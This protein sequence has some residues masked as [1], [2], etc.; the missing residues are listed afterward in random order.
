[1]PVAIRKRSW[2]EHV[3]HP[4]GL[5]YSYDDLD[6]V[7]C[8][9]VDSEGPWVGAGTSKQGQRTRC[10]SMPEGCHQLPTDDLAQALEVTA[11][12]RNG[13]TESEHL[14]LMKNNEKVPMDLQEESVHS[15]HNMVDVDISQRASESEHLQTTNMGN[16][17]KFHCNSNSVMSSTNISCVTDS[18]AQSDKTINREGEVVTE[19]R[20]SHDICN[21]GNVFK[22]LNISHDVQQCMSV[23]SHNG[24]PLSESAGEQ[25][26]K[27]PDH[28]ETKESHTEGY[29][30]PPEISEATLNSSTAVELEP[31]LD[32]SQDEDK[33]IST[34]DH[35]GANVTLPA[36]VLHISVMEG[37]D[38]MSPASKSVEPVVTLALEEGC[39]KG[40]TENGS[41]DSA[42]KPDGLNNLE[43]QND[44][45]GFK[46]QSRDIQGGTQDHQDCTWVLDH[47]HGCEMTHQTFL[48]Q[49]NFEM[50]GTT[51]PQG[52]ASAQEESS[53]EAADVRYGPVTS[54]DI[55][56]KG[57]CCSMTVN[58]NMLSEK[59]DTGYS[60]EDTTQT[61]TECAG[62]CVERMT[63]LSQKME[64]MDQSS[65]SKEL[66]SSEDQKIAQ[67]LENSCLKLDTVHE[68]SHVDPSDTPVLDPE[69]IIASD[70]TQNPAVQH[71]C[72]NDKHASTEQ[73]TQ[74]LPPCSAEVNDELSPEELHD[75]QAS[76]H[77]F[78]ESAV[79]EV[80]DG[81]REHH[82]PRSTVSRMEDTD[83]AVL[84][85]S[86][87]PEDL[88]EDSLVKVRMRKVRQY[89]IDIE[90][91]QCDNFT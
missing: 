57:Q 13:K 28:Q 82:R 35:A 69:K 14:K 21:D 59:V 26:G 49:H 30:R 32:L 56:F 47:A 37:G 6:L 24:L 85:G 81:Q 48:E 27:L 89:D 73:H 41:A 9:G 74:N 71:P 51:R 17:Q 67:Q 44:K 23:S 10:A 29:S 80:A 5:Q 70:R 54:S 78:N 34:T 2:E 33:K 19:S 40:L 91:I 7:C 52:E 43:A 77:Y 55:C 72:M 42:D 39:D 68:V 1:M 15:P 38:M 90:K 31:Q 86:N 50:T 46:H 65:R 8:H 64:D 63:S 20:Q 83:E 45:I 25:P 76:G 75:N 18:S 88:K 87:E 60:E 53:K 16:F 58:N 4:S 11:S 62:W 84:D 66:V 3:T 12:V 61:N 22:S 79:S 36:G